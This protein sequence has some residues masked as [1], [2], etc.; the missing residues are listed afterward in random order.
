MAFKIKKL[1]DMTQEAV[2]HDIGANVGPSSDIDVPT[3][4]GSQDT[5]SSSKQ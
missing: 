2:A 3:A 5:P 1:S 4:S